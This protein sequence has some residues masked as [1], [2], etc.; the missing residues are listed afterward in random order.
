MLSPYLYLYG[1]GL[2]D[3]LTCCCCTKMADELY[4]VPET[5][6]TRLF[7]RNGDVFE[8]TEVFHE[9]AG[10]G[11]ALLRDAARFKRLQEHVLT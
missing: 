1:S 4:Y 8:M 7:D 10:L 2:A 5:R 3:Q 6:E 9:G 11:A